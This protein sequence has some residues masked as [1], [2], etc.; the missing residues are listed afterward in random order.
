M[1]ALPCYAAAPDFGRVPFTHTITVTSFKVGFHNI[2]SVFLL[3]EEEET[4]APPTFPLMVMCERADDDGPTRPVFG[5]LLKRCDRYDRATLQGAHRGQK[6]VLPRKKYPFR[7]RVVG[8]DGVGPR[9]KPAY[10]RSEVPVPV[11]PPASLQPWDTLAMYVDCLRGGIGRLSEV[12]Q[13]IL[14]AQEFVEEKTKATPE[15]D[16]AWVYWSG[17]SVLNLLAS[18]ATSKSTD[19]SN[20]M[21]KLL[22]ASPELADALARREQQDAAEGAS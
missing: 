19:L 11:P 18:A 13:G 6:H 10:A 12:A 2:G 15:S 16:H 21:H 1:T 7:W 9:S 5:R 4:I 3:V 14:A 17:Y 20:E 22:R 8:V